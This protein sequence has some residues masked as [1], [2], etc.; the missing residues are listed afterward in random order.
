M[1][2]REMAV[3]SDARHRRSIRLPGYDYA[4]AGAY[5]VTLVTQDRGCLFEDEAFHQ[6][7]EETWKWLADQYQ[8]VCLDE[9]VVMPNH[10]HGILG[11]TEPRRGRFANRPYGARKRPQTPR[12]PGRRFQDGINQTHQPP[13]WHARRTSLAT[14]LI[15]TCHSQRRGAQPHPPV[16]RR[17]PR[18][19]AR[20]PR[21]SNGGGSIVICQQGDHVATPG[22][23]PTTAL[24]T[25]PRRGGSRTAPTPRRRA[26]E[27]PGRLG[28]PSRL[29]SSRP[30]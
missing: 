4:S 6:I 19:L 20:R 13:P 22:P 16:H 7:V 29:T 8:H 1:R 5:F 21:E 15:R 9:Y 23:F 12:T 25:E 2:V 17:Q 24:I 10:F 18:E 26:F 30:C 11:I 27:P 14:Q 28:A 3:D